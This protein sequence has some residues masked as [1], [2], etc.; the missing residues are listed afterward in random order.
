MKFYKDEL[1]SKEEL[2]QTLRAFQ[3]SSNELKSKDRDDW[4]EMRMKAQARTIVEEAGN[5]KFD[6]LDK[7]G[8]M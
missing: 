3:A 1:L 8:R 7:L 2:A 4:I 5:G 6:T